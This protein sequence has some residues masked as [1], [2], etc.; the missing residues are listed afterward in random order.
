MLLCTAIIYML[1]LWPKAPFGHWP[2]GFPIF[3]TVA[4][5][6]CTTTTGVCEANEGK[7]AAPP[8]SP[9]LL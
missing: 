5:A 3:F 6:E 7:L 4:F 2:S 1:F 8:A 9:F